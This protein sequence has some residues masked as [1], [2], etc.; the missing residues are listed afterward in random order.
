MII[1]KNNKRHILPDKGKMLARIDNLSMLFSEIWLGDY[2][3]KKGHIIMDTPD[4]Y[5]DM[6][7]INTKQ[8]L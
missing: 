6:D 4:N 7:I 1:D 3:D 5:I 8:V 2:L